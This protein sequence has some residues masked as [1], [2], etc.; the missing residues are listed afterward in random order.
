MIVSMSLPSDVSD[1]VCSNNRVIKNK[2]E[3]FLVIAYVATV[4]FGEQILLS[5]SFC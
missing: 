4:I 1:T 3:Y 2:G 5:C